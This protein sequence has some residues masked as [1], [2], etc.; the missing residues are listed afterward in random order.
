MNSKNVKHSQ[1]T[2]QTT[3]RATSQSVGPAPS[4]GQVASSLASAGLGAGGDVLVANLDETVLLGCVGEPADKLDVPDAT[5]VAM[6]LD[7]SSSMQPHQRAVIE[8]HGTMLDALAGA[9]AATSILVST[10]GFADTAQ[11]LGSYEEVTRKPKLNTAV[12]T[13][14]GC[15]ALH[16][17]VLAAMTGLVA[18]GEALWQNGVPTRRV[19]VVM[20]DGEDNASKASAFDVRR[21]AK[22]LAAQ[23]AYTLAYAGFGGDLRAQADAL[24]FSQVIQAGATDAEIRRVFRQVSAGVLRTSAG[25]SAG[26]SLG[27]GFF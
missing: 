3:S 11:L 25:A 5:L 12:Y 23:E 10:W 21:A 15:T 27:T 9:K 4:R 6:V 16:D 19:L 24:G 17:A 22:A 18:Y 7:M 14:N 13:T 8:A 2:S 26:S 1:T 20:T